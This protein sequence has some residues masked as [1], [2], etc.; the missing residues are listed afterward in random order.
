MR[1]TRQLGPCLAKVLAHQNGKPAALGGLVAV[2]KI[3]HLT[4]RPPEFLQHRAV[5]M[6]LGI[7]R[8]KRLVDARPSPAAVIRPGHLTAR[9]AMPGRPDAEHRLSVIGKQCR[10]M[11]LVAVFRTCGDYDLTS[12]IAGNVDNGQGILRK[13]RQQA[14]RRPEHDC[15]FHHKFSLTDRQIA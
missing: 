13:C 1:L 6:R 15:S 8:R 2:D 10:R 9:P 7:D 5:A 11:P 12:G 14:T 3:A 4:V